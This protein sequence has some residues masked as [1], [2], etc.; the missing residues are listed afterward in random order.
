MATGVTSQAFGQQPIANLVVGPNDAFR[1][2][3]HSCGSLASSA[4]V[5]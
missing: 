3:M 4:G 1:S 5:D 2:R